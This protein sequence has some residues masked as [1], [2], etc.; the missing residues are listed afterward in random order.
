M[1]RTRAPRPSRAAPAGHLKGASRV[2]AEYG[3][4]HHADFLKTFHRQATQKRAQKKKTHP[5]TAEEHTALRKQIGRVH[6]I[7]PDYADCTKANI[8]GILGKWQ[9]YCCFNADLFIDCKPAVWKAS[10][11]NAGWRALMATFDWR[12]LLKTSDRAVFMSFL[13]SICDNYH[14]KSWGPRGSTSASSSSSLPLS[15]T[16]T[17]TGMIAR[18]CLRCVFLPPRPQHFP[19]HVGIYG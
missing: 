15:A 6:F 1:S 2:A 5:L 9:L 16:N 17:W 12:S 8:S 14:I 13:Y 10:L 3:T 4:A 7:T 11:T 18:R 19:W